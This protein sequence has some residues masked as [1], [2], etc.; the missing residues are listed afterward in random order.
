MDNQFLQDRDNNSLKILPSDHLVLLEENEFEKYFVFHPSIF[1]LFPKSGHTRKI[2]IKQ[3]FRFSLML[4][5]GYRVYL[6]AT[7]DDVIKCSIVYSAGGGYRFPFSTKNDLI[8][9][10]SFTIPAFRNQGVATRLGDKVMNEFET[11]YNIVY[12]TVKKDNISCIKNLKKNGFIIIGNVT[13]TK[14]KQAVLD[15]NGEMILFAY[16]KKRS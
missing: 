5:S 16:Y 2:D 15:K 12:A 13:Y 6:S 4:F 3:F 9:G 7:H 1:K 10:P 11:D 8:D 14:R